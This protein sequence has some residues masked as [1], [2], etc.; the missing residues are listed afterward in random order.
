MERNSVTTPPTSSRP[1]RVHAESFEALTAPLFDGLFRTALWLARTHP[2][3]QDLVQKTYL[4]AFRGYRSLRDPSRCRAWMV[5]ILRTLWAKDFSLARR[6]PVHVALDNLTEEWV[7]TRD[8]S[9]GIGAGM[10]LSR[11]LMSL[12]EEFRLAVLL[13]DSDGLTYEQAARVF[14]CPVGTVW[15]RVSRGRELIVRAMSP[16]TATR[17]LRVR[18]RR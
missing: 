2:D 17:N 9:E 10:D 16:T 5:G 15:S 4:E 8:P 18:P 7:A 14:A 12:P 13:V 11:V 6:Q 3:A 1:N